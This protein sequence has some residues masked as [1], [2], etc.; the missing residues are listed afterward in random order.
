MSDNDAV[1][2][3]ALAS[4]ERIRN[5]LR[6][7]IRRAY[8]THE[9]TRETLATESGV[10]VCQIDQI[11]SRDAAKHRRVTAEDALNLAYTLGEGAVSS[12][13]ATIRYSAARLDDAETINAH[14]I[15]AT[16]LP[17]VSTIA[18]AAADGR[19]DHTERPVCQQAADSI[20]AT[21]MPLSSAGEA[22]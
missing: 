10:N 2:S 22:A 20:I 9:F 18:I 16:L 1:Q 7:H 14:M 21:V 4:D 11:M 3:S 17:H 8:D 12:L 6:R 15:V 13:V 5:T 19:F